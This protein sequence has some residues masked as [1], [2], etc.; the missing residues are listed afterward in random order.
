MADT[1]A[2]D[3]DLERATDRLVDAI[4]VRG[5]RFRDGREKLHVS[6][7]PIRQY[8]IAWAMA[9]GLLIL[10]SGAGIWSARVRHPAG[11]AYATSAGQRIHLVLDDGTRI[12][13]APESRLD[14]S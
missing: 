2:H 8:P 6:A 10:L 7:N 1:P 11:R 3:D 5:A 4:A 9:A 14:V 12:T 13:L